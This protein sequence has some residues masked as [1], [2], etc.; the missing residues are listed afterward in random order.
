VYVPLFSY[1]QAASPD[2][3]V[4]EEDRF[5]IAGTL[6]LMDDPREFLYT[7]RIVPQHFRAH[8]DPALFKIYKRVAP[9]IV[10]VMVT[11][12]D[13]AV[14]GCGCIGRIMD[15]EEPEVSIFKRHGGNRRRFF[16]VMIS[17]NERDAAIELV[18]V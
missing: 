12:D 8:V 14:K 18:T 5:A 7:Y 2:I 9:A 16:S 15:E 3:R 10:V 1:R 13:P 4:P 11:V 17:R 6:V